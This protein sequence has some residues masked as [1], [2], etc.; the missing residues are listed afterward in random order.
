M[1]GNVV[2][3]TDAGIILRGAKYETRLLRGSGV[4][5]ADHCQLD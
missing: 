3:E 2:K 5:K 4:S 1:M